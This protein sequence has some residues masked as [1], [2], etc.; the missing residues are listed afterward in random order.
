[1]QIFI[2]YDIIFSEILLENLSDKK[3][4]VKI[5]NLSININGKSLKTE[6]KKG[7]LDSNKIPSPYLTGV[8]DRIV[9]MPYSFTASLETNRG[10]PYGCAY[11]DYGSPLTYFKNIVPLDEQRVKDEIE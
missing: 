1:M 2:V 4:F 11:C 6:G 8:F 9:K 3:D 10:C 5:N 7:N